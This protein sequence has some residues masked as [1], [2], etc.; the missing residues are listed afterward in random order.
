M[1]GQDQRQHELE[2]GIRDC[3]DAPRPLLIRMMKNITFQ[4]SATLA[5]R[6]ARASSVFSL[7]AGEEVARGMSWPSAEPAPIA[8]DSWRRTHEDCA[9]HVWSDPVSKEHPVAHQIVRW[10]SVSFRPH[11]TRIAPVLAHP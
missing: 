6:N 7:I 2:V 10:F 11:L 5:C 1:R 3:P 8:S 9:L 4:K